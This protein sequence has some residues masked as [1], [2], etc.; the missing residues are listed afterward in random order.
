[1]G[2]W[3]KEWF[4]Q[5]NICD[6]DRIDSIPDEDLKDKLLRERILQDGS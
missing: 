6:F 4:C 3:F 5:V 1:M 2:Y